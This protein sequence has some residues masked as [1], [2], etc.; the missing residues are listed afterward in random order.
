MAI[1][2]KIDGTNICPGLNSGE[3]GAT[4]EQA[5]VFLNMHKVERLVGLYR[6]ADSDH[7]QLFKSACVTVKKAV[8][9]VPERE[10]LKMKPSLCFIIYLCLNTMVHS[11]SVIIY[12]LCCSVPNDGGK[13]RV[14]ISLS[15]LFSPKFV[16]LFFQSFVLF[17]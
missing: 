4:F 17:F 8:C 10:L 11:V 13:G 1:F 2:F 6:R 16:P 14:M 7:I 12:S 15:R 9:R 3:L 5:L